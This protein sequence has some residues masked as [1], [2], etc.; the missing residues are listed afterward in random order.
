MSEF[1]LT[2]YFCFRQPDII[3]RFRIYHSSL[4]NLLPDLVFQLFTELL[5]LV[6]ISGS[7]REYSENF[8]KY[9]ESYEKY[10]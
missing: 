8:R 5:Q 9:P 6:N 7:I 4:R 2:F 1:Q 3:T 10:S